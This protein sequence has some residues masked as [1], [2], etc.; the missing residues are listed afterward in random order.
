MTNENKQISAKNGDV[1]TSYNDAMSLKQLLLK[2]AKDSI[3]KK[4]G[5]KGS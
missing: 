2:K 1:A 3:E 5:K 4:D